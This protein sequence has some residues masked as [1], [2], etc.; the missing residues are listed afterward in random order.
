ME[1]IAKDY[2]KLL[3]ESFRRALEKIEQN[4]FDNSTAKNFI[5]TT[6]QISFSRFPVFQSKFTELLLKKNNQRVE[7]WVKFGY[8]NLDDKSQ[9]ENNMNHQFEW[10]S[11]HEKLE[12]IYSKKVTTSVNTMINQKKW[13]DLVEKRSSRC[14]QIIAFWIKIL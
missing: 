4:Q 12:E 11:F 5:Q 1:E 7:E 13:A 3:S 9:Y 6:I 8:Q 14:F 10:N 2:H